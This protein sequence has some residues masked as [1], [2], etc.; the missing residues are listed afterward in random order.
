MQIHKKSSFLLQATKLDP[1]CYSCYVYLG[2]YYSLG[3]KNL[4]KARRCY[5]KAFHINPHCK[6]AGAAL[7][8]IYRLQKNAVSI[9]II[10]SST[11]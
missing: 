7:S 8:D 3:A 5:Q 9:I 10:G 1:N 2:N 4:D 11:Y 6:E